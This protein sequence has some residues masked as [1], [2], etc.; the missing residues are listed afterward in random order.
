MANGSTFLQ[1]IRSDPFGFFAMARRGGPVVFSDHVASWNVFGYAETVEVLRNPA[2]YS[3]DVA[4]YAGGSS[5]VPPRSLLGLDPP[6]HTQLR[7][8]VNAAFTRSQVAALE[9]RI[10]SLADELMD[11]AQANDS[12]DVMD[13]L[14]GPLPV[15]M[16]A[17]LLG[18]PKED[19]PAFMRWSDTISTL[20]GQGAG[21]GGIAPG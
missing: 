2:V 15:S 19:R 21:G 9:P 3:S 20:I 11:A 1:M 18:I 12:F 8:L 7:N 4:R 16:I 14:A 13:D 17:A 10:R 6:R 5:E